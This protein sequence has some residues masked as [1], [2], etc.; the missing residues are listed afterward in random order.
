MNLILCYN[1]S[2]PDLYPNRPPTIWPHS[3]EELLVNGKYSFILE[4]Y[5]Y[6]FAE[7]TPA[8]ESTWFDP[9]FMKTDP[10]C[11][12]ITHNNTRC[13]NNSTPSHD[14]FCRIHILHPPT[15]MYDDLGLVALTEFHTQKVEGSEG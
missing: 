9:N 8:D 12:A 7:L 4:N 2:R 3:E 1:P 11:R 10:Q 6:F 5:I 13:P 15:A 14:F